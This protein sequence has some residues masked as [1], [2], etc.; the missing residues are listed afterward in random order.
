MID[1]RGD[2]LRQP[3]GTT[4]AAVKANKN[5]QWVPL[6]A[7]KTFIRKK[8]KLKFKTSAGKILRI[9]TLKINAV[10]ILNLEWYEP[11]HDKTNKMIC[12]PIK[13]SRSAWASAQCDQSL[14]VGF[15]GS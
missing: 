12:A 2:V 13:D 3:H 6:R 5:Q 7:M 10:I 15:M 9:G 8:T 4:P 14:A 11:E 1:V